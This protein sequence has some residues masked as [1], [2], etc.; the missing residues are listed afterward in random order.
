MQILTCGLR[1]EHLFWFS[2]EYKENNSYQLKTQISII[3]SGSVDALYSARMQI[4]AKNDVFP[5][6]KV[7]RSEVK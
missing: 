5:F 1:Q 6:R 2:Y 3:D 4:Q 7:N